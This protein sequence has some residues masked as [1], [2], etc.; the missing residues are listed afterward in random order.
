MDDIRKPGIDVLR[1]VSML[2]VVI[3]HVNMRGG[4][5]N[6]TTD[7]NHEV[8]LLIEA[9]SLCAVNVFAM[10]SVFLNCGKPLKYKKIIFLWRDI[11]IYSI[12]ILMVFLI[13]DRDIVGCEE[14]LNAFFPILTGAYWYYSSYMI[15][16]ITIPCLNAGIESLSKNTCKMCILLMVCLLSVSSFVGDIDA[17]VINKGYSPLWLMTMYLIGAYYRRYGFPIKHKVLTGILIYASGSGA[18]W[19]SHYIIRSV[20][21]RLIVSSR[22]DELMLYS[23]T[24]PMIVIAAL[25]L[26]IAFS[27]IT[28]TKGIDVFKAIAPLCTSVYIIHMNPLVKEYFLSDRFAV[29]ASYSVFGMLSAMLGVSLLIM[30]I[31]LFIDYL[32]RKIFSFCVCFKRI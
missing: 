14:L 2:M 23:Y 6:N 5:L 27:S 26:L 30:V 12:V 16:V 18:T 8:S 20:L 17:F 24:S 25:G 4:I 22:G 32:R 29:F 28:I 1:V 21:T 19:L 9:F 31:C 10:L 7:I 3:L 11:V 15:M 13:I